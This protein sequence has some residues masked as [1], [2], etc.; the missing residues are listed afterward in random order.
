MRLADAV[1]G[2]A[3]TAPAAQ[4]ATAALRLA[5]RARAAALLRAG[6]AAAGRPPRDQMAAFLPAALTDAYLRQL[7][8]DGELRRPAAMPLLL[9]A[10]SL[11]RRP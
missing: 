9:A 4:E 3:E 11:L 6:R 1:R 5:A 8:N 2:E 10:R 7:A